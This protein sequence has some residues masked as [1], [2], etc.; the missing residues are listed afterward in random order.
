MVQWCTALSGDL[1][2]LHRSHGPTSEAEYK[3]AP[4]L[5]GKCHRILLLKGFAE[6]EWE[7]WMS[8][9]G[10]RRRRSSAANRLIGEV[11]QSQRRPLLGPSPG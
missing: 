7:K 10:L 2:N 3:A 5:N 11:V 4:L 9:V 8:N 1:V 6:I